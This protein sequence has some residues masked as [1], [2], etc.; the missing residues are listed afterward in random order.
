MKGGSRTATGSVEAGGSC[1]G[2]DD[3]GT[4]SVEVDEARES[5]GEWMVEFTHIEVHHITTVKE[6]NILPGSYYLAVHYAVCFS[7]PKEYNGVGWKVNA[8]GPQCCRL[9]YTQQILNKHRFEKTDKLQL[10]VPRSTCATTAEGYPKF[11]LANHQVGS[12]INCN[13]PSRYRQENMHGGL[14]KYSLTRVKP[15]FATYASNSTSLYIIYI[16]NIIREYKGFLPPLM[17][18]TLSILSP[19][20]VHA[21]DARVWR[22]VIHPSPRDRIYMFK[23]STFL[24]QI[25]KAT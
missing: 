11:N 1:G 10:T 8:H 23:H 18:P 16:Y 17:T 21:S 13:V 5:G 4:S 3:G 2:G 9:Q 19:T 7:K 25:P 12:Q 24:S 14:N 20:Y 22:R 6:P 15:A